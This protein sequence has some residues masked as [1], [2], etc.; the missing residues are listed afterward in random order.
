MRRK[1]EGIVILV[2]GLFLLV[3]LIT[4][5]AVGLDGSP[6][7]EL[8]PHALTGDAGQLALVGTAWQHPDGLART[9]AAG[10]TEYAGPAA[11]L[12]PRIQ[13]MIDQ[14]DGGILSQYVGDLSGEWPVIVGGDWVTLTTRYTLSGEPIQKAVQFVADRLEAAGLD[15]E[16]HAWAQDR[17][18]NVVAEL[19]G[20]THP[21]EVYILCAHLDSYT[22]Q[23]PM[24]LAPGADDNAS[25]VAV[26]LHAAEILTRY[27]WGCTLRFAL[28]TGEEQGLWGSYYYAKRAYTA[29]ETIAGVLNLDMIAWD[30]IEGPDLDLHAKQTLVPSSI[31]LAEL[32]SDVVGIY[33][34]NLIPQI[35]SNG[36]SA[37]D[38]ASFWDWGYPAI[39]GIE[40]YEPSGN[41]FNPYY[42]SDQDLLQQLN[43][44][45]FTEFARA[46][47]GA[48][49]H[50]GCLL[51]E[52]PTQWHFYLPLIVRTG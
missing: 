43:L 28:W 6:S 49:A 18:P 14:V 13:A 16:Y 50:M 48:F 17:P 2:A 40:D 44:A 37:S 19:R 21:D 36:S 23:S 22:R 3:G 52:G 45:Y 30:G 34:L 29:G 32:F 27:R 46:A 12:D 24:V 42:H 25:G 47:V 35:V 10:I 26:V 39:L 51:P 9:E 31:D 4:V 1:L 15:V 20:G 8:S 11:T 38:Q 5:S 33:D 7:A 41:D